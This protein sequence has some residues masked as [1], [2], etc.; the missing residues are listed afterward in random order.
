MS[1]ASKNITI[2]FFILMNLLMIVSCQ[3]KEV[4]LENVTDVSLESN[5]ICIPHS[6]CIDE[7]YL[8]FQAENCS[9]SKPEKCER[10]CLNASCRSGEICAVGFKCID[11]NRRGYQK[12]DCS[13]ATKIDCEWGCET[14]KCKEKPANATT[15]TS[16]TTVAS[17]TGYSAIAENAEEN[18]T[19]P[20]GP[21]YTLQLGEE[22]QINI[23]GTT[24]TIKIHNLEVDRVMIKINDIKSDW[25]TEGSSFTYAN[26]GT[27]VTIKSIL[28]QAYGKKEIEYYLNSN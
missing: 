17:S 21:F 7:N 8:R 23:D 28:F 27:T 16:N 19:V 6:E 26:F 24:Y 12:E 9:W 20:V 22:G 11:E 4:Q 10:G 13:F 25:I 3:P 5:D 14:G 18:E 15:E 2:A 1:K